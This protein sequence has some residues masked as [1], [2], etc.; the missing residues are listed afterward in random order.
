MCVTAKIDIMKTSEDKIIESKSTNVYKVGV[1]GS[2]H[3]YKK[4]LDLQEDDVWDA[5]LQVCRSTY[6]EELKSDILPFW[7]KNGWD[8]VNGGFY[9]CVDRDGSLMDSTKSVWFQGRSAFTFSYAYNYIEKNPDWLSAS[10]SAIEFME[11][12]CFD[13]QGRMYFEVTA[14]GEP[15]RQRRYLFSE[16]FAAL[17]MAEYSRAS[18]D[19]RYAEKALEIFKLILHYKNTPGAL[20]S[21][22]ESH[23]ELKGHSLTMILINTAFRIREVIQHE[24]LDQQIR[25]SIREIR[26]YF[27]KPEFE[28]VLETVGAN[29]AFIDTG[30]GRTINP[31]HAL[32]TGWFILEEARYRNWDPELVQMATTII[33]WSWKWGWDQLYGGIINYRDCKNWPSQEYNHD[34]KFWWPQ[35]EG[36]I[37]LLY[38]YRAT[39]DSKYLKMHKKLHDYTFRYFPDKSYGEW[40][41]Y[42]HRTGTV[43]QPAKGN[44]FKG[45]FHIPRMLMIGYLLTDELLTK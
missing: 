9:T 4:T 38:A 7:L 37:A 33:D 27:M 26:E 42:L 28:A 24:I 36:I 5:H 45:P 10:R 2:Q 20:S 12:H 15:V 43:S 32:E 34:M 16:C 39:G 8:R 23:Y 19:R 13:V 31:G 25:D 17:G 30:L 3:Q 21:K 41:G 1:E 29:G 6:L 14:T 22:Y 35:T 44:L 11:A 18:G 40:Y